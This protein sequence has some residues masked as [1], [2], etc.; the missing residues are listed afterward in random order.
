MF[1][2]SGRGIPFPECCSS[3]SRRPNR[4]PVGPGLG[5]DQVR[6]DAQNPFNAGTP[7]T[8][9]RLSRPSL[10]PLSCVSRKTSATGGGS[11]TTRGSNDGS[12]KPNDAK[13]STLRVGDHSHPSGRGFMFTRIPSSSE[14]RLALNVEGGGQKETARLSGKRFPCTSGQR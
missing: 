14:R 4:L 11:T 1:Q 8:A 10:W 7:A 2:H 3:R 12:S 5:V 6:V 9:G 13:A